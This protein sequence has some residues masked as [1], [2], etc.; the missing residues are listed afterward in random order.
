MVGK[1]EGM[2]M[3]MEIKNITCEKGKISLTVKVPV[4]EEHSNNLTRKGLFKYFAEAYACRPV[5]K[6]SQKL[7]NSFPCLV[8]RG[9]PSCLLREGEGEKRREGEGGRR[10]KNKLGLLDFSN[11]FAEFNGS[12]SDFSLGSRSFPN[13]E[14]KLEGL[15]T[16]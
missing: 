12:L 6:T 10:E 7:C 2:G 15:K 5:G 4:P 3:E 16:K 9:A 1:E 8:R 11:F 13:P 14:R